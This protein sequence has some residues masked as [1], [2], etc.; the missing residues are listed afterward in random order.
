MTPSSTSFRL[1][2]VLAASACIGYA[3]LALALTWPLAAHLRTALPGDP[4]GDTGVYVWNLWIFRHEILAHGHLPFTTQH[5]FAFTGGTD[6]SLHN[7]TPLAGL[8]ALPLISRFGVVG[9]FNL[10]LMLVLTLSGAGLYG[11]GRHVGLRRS[12]AWLA[13]ALFMAAPLISARET[14]HLSLVTNAALPLFLWTLLRVLDQPGFWRAM[15]VGTAVAAATYSDAYYGIF[16]VIMGAFVVAWRLLRVEVTR[17]SGASRRLTRTIAVA[18]TAMLALAVVPRIIGLSRVAVGSVSIR[19]L[20]RPYTPLLLLVL[21]VGFHTWLHFRPT[22]RP[23]IPGRLPRGL[24]LS[25]AVAVIGC[26]LMLSPLLLG[27]AERYS[28]GRLPSTPIYWRSSPRGVDLLA[29]LVPNPAHV[30]IGRFSERWLLPDVQ[31]AFPELVASYSILAIAAVAIAALWRLLPRM[32]IAFTGFFVLLSL[33]P[34]VHIGGLN[35]YVMGPGRCCAITDHRHGAFSFAVR[36]RRGDGLSLLCAFAVQ[37]WLD[38]RRSYARVTV[39]IFVCL[40]AVEMVPGPRRLFSAAVPDVY[41]LVAASG[42]EA[43]RLLELPTG[44]RDG[45]SSLGNFSA[46]TSYFQTAH[47]RP[48]VGGYLSRVSEWRKQESLRMPM[49]RALY[50]LS[51]PGGTVDESL[52]VDARASR[53]VFLARS[54]VRFVLVDK[55]AATERLRTFAREALELSPLYE[56]E[57]YQLLAPEHPPDCRG[58][59]AGQRGSVRLTRK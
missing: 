42:D 23:A 39:G 26:L 4:G 7:Y 43:G 57:R 40:L 38:R 36:H 16:C 20:D 15:L 56:D 19:D 55:R 52:A 34:F 1:R 50:Q 2:L 8:L 24:A 17:A 46:S 3:L 5:I 54:C 18:A 47:G 21:L 33:G 28:Q 58:V 31:D 14:A 48:L 10:V 12:A 41:R 37:A 35:T 49:L 9:A 59:G 32:W 25:G 27:I 13:G 6:F 53:D 22:V 30:W 44:I 29:Y 11:L 51:E 45:A